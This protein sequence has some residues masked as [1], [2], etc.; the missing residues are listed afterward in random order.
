MNDH[1]PSLQI[2]HDNKVHTQKQIL[3][4]QRQVRKNHN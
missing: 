4:R 2:R 3:N 1:P